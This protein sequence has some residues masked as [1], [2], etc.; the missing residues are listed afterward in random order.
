M[1]IAISLSLKG[2]FCNPKKPVDVEQL[3]SIASVLV[4]MK[5]AAA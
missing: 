4:T 2:I 3:I 5:L 1:L